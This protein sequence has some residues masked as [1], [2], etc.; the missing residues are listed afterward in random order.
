MKDCAKSES[1]SLMDENEERGKRSGV[2]LD[3]GPLSPPDRSGLLGTAMLARC[4]RYG[5]CGPGCMT[6][7]L[8]R[9]GCGVAVWVEVSTDNDAGVKTLPKHADGRWLAAPICRSGRPGGTR[10]K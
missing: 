9:V 2:G 8:G 7:I 4:C 6:A 3:G 10:R 1:C 5:W